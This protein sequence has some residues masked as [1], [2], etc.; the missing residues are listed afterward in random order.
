MGDSCAPGYTRAERKKR[1]RPGALK[2]AYELA[3]NANK[4]KSDFL[5][6]M[7]H[8]IRT[9]LRCCHRYDGAGQTA[10]G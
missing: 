3:Q 9:P 1:E 8:D 5:S 2:E 4:A 7:S 6:K 10:Y